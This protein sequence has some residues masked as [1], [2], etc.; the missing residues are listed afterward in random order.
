QAPTQGRE[1]REAARRI[2][3]RVL[4]FTGIAFGWAS[5]VKKKCCSFSFLFAYLCLPAPCSLHSKSF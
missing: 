3:D 5:L 4:F 2:T 1:H